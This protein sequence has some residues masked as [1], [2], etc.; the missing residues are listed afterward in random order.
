MDLKQKAVSDKEYENSKSLYLTLKIRNLN[1]MNDLYNP[2]DRT[3]L[4]EFIENRFKLM[5]NTYDFNARKCNSAS[6]LSGCI[7]RDLSKF[8]IPLP[9][10][11]AIVE[12]FEKTVTSVLVVLIK[13]QLLILKF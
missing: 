2:Q 4:C 12:I 11:K 1:D 10:S 5:C 8:I 13:D 3:L 6:T 9:T 7:E